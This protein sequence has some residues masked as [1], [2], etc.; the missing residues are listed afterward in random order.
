VQSATRLVRIVGANPSRPGVASDPVDRVERGTGM[1]APVLLESEAPRTLSAKRGQ[2]TM[3]AT[4]RARHCLGATRVP[5]PSRSLAPA[6]VALLAQ[7]RTRR[8]RRSCTGSHRRSK[9][10]AE[11]GGDFLGQQHRHGQ[12]AA[13]RRMPVAPDRVERLRGRL[14]P[15]VALGVRSADLPCPPKERNRPLRHRPNLRRGQLKT[16]SALQVRRPR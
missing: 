5:P 8:A 1:D 11:P 9:G 7:G 14:L 4:A 12:L 10:V 6:A 16:S 13:N 15:P 2:A 3:A